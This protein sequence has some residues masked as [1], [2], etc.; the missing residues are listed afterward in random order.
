MDRN[1]T[2]EQ[3]TGR[4]PGKGGYP[5]QGGRKRQKRKMNKN[6]HDGIA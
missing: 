5:P 3:G 6:E 1:L 4:G 2:R